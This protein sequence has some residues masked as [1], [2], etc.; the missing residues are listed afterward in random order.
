M[1]LRPFALERYFAKYEFSVKH[2]LCASDCETRTIADLEAL[3]PGL[4]ARLASLRLGYIDSRGTP[5]LRRVIAGMYDTMTP[6]DVL[7]CSG[8]QEAI[9]WFYFA[10]LEAGDEVVVHT[11]CYASHAEVPR[12]LGAVVVPWR[13]DPADGDRLD[14]GALERLRTPRTRAVVVNTPHNPTGYLMSRPDF[15]ALHRWADTH[16]ITVFSDEVFRESEQDPRDRLPAACDASPHAVSLGVT[17]KTYGLAGLRVGW[18]ATKNHALLDAMAA[19]KDYSTI[20]G[21]APNELLAEVAMRH[22]DALAKDNVARIRRNL[23][24]LDAFFDRHREHFAWRRP[25]AGTVAFVRLLS[26]DVEAFCRDLVES[27]GVLLLPG[28]VFDDQ[29]QRFRIGFGREDLPQAVE[30]LDAFVIERFGAAAS[31]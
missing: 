15:D 17:S 2:V 19:L 27:T 30:R 13:G 21:G 22:R 5:S 26:G 9:L 12:A 31:C 24:V 8:A 10:A 23:D 7:V 25:R 6:E 1:K 11:P 28:S 4:L 16:R 29:D 14:L 20:C 18:V 3:E